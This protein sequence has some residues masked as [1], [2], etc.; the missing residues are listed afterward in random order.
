MKSHGLVSMQFLGVHG[1]FF[2]AKVKESKNAITE[3]YQNLPYATLSGA[4][5]DAISDLVTKLSFSIK[6]ST[7]AN[8]DR[9]KKED[10]KENVIDTTTFKEL[11]DLFEQEI[12]DDLFKD[13]QHKKTKHPYVK[14]QVKDA[15]TIE[16]ETQ[17]TNCKFLKLKQEF[18][19]V[20]TTA[21]EQKWQ[22]DATNF[23]DDILDEDNLFRNIDTEDIWI[24]DGLFDD[25]DTQALK[26]ILKTI[27]DM[28]EPIETITVTDDNDKFNPIETI[29]IEDDIDIPTQIS[30]VLHLIE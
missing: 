12:V 2:G 18:D 16:I 3:L 1:I 23:I 14:P 13:L 5:F 25:Y 29:T 30:Y 15:Q 20:N 4:N 7:L 22:T 17:T 19:M 26:D 11:P 8:R 9:R 27:S 21:T 6:K 24:E 10:A 28:A